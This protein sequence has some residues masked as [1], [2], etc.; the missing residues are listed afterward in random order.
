[1]ISYGRADTSLRAQASALRCSVKALFFALRR[2]GRFTFLNRCGRLGRRCDVA[3]AHYLSQYISSIAYA[4]R[5][6]QMLKAFARM[7]SEGDSRPVLLRISIFDIPH[8]V[9]RHSAVYTATAM[10]VAFLG[11]YHSRADRASLLSAVSHT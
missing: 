2:R 1:M 10:G 6:R 9:R 5:F 7:K 11:D 8:A 4:P 3:H